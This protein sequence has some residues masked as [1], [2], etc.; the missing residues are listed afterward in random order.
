MSWIPML[1]QI[2]VLS[3]AYYYILLFF[4]GTRGAQI[5]VGLVLL[6]AALIAV[7]NLFRL[8][9]LNWVI[10][11]LS[12]Y[13]AIG[14]LVIF[15]PEVR[16]AL[17][18]IGKQP[19]FGAAREERTAVDHVVEA[20]GALAEHRVGALIAI[21]R[22]IGTLAVQESGV[23]LDAKVA[24]ELLASIFYPHTPLHDG[25]VIIRG[26]RIVAAG[27]VFPIS[28]RTDL[29]RELGTRHRAAIGLSEETDAVVIV[30]SEETGTIS[31][32]YRGRLTRGLDPERLK[33]FLA[34]LL[35]RAPAAGSTWR[36][37]QD[38]LD[39]TPHGIATSERLAEEVAEEDE[40][41]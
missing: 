30:V 17:A 18:E 33:R 20:V 36:R 32:C 11:R 37:V 39:L 41:V 40:H 28:Q 24:P 8:D 9:E 26:N 4:R 13:L 38:R 31:A 3:A 14:V 19:A 29:L 35:L 34:A 15:Q 6:V 27:C 23:R 2:A 22:E 25:G 12:V 5:L 1:V 10:S 7:T 21:E 16:R